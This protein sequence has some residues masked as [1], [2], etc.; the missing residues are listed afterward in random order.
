MPMQLMNPFVENI[1]QQSLFNKADRLLIAVSGGLDSVVL[2]HLCKTA[3]FDFAIAH[4]NFQL[5]GAESDLDEQFVQ[6]LGKA[7]QVPV[8]TKKFNLE[9]DADGKTNIQSTARTLRYEW[10]AECMHAHEVQARYLLTAHHANDNIETLLMNFFRGTGI[11]GLQGILPRDYIFGIQVVRPL[12]FATKASLRNYAERH[13]L[14]WR[15]DASNATSQYTRNY[16]RNELIPAIE[17]VFPAVESNLMDNIQRF[18]DAHALYQQ[19]IQLNI[20][21]W[22]DTKDEVLRMPVLLIKKTPGY[23]SVLYEILHQKGFSA[24]QMTDCLNLLE[25]DTG[26]YVQSATHRV[27]KNRKWLEVCALSAVTVQNVVI[28]EGVATVSFAMGTL[29]IQSKEKPSAITANPH[30]IQLD[31]KNISFPLLLRKWREGDYFYPLGMNKKK[32]ISRFLIDTKQSLSAKENT[33]VLESANRL[34]WVVGQRMDNRFKLTEQS[35]AV[36]AITW[37]PSQ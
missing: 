29:K 33:W 9:S 19:A 27:I 15:E 5:R 26:K 31:A 21:K 11:N 6:A 12:L 23:A 30:S 36:L 25:A 3:G 28:E 18:V 1:Q 32:K 8:Y 7:Y 35:T 34:V 2:C 22:V 4:A 14:N 17:K 16:F 13:Q 10:F 37:L 24:A 20:S